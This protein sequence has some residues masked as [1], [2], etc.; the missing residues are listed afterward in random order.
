M[1][2]ILQVDDLVKRFGGVLAT[3]N[4]AL[5][6]EPGEVHALIGPN[7]AGKTTL[8]S[9]LFGELTPDAGTIRFG[10]QAIG[11]LS[12]ADRVQRGLS[13]TFQI[14][15][16]LREFTVLENVAMAV[17]VRRGHSFH[18]WRN[19]RRDRSLS[20]AAYGILRGAGLGD[21]ADVVVSELSHGEQ[22]QLEL[23]VALA[24]EPRLLLLDEPMAGLGPVESEA[25][26]A[27]LSKLKGQVA[28]L[29]V[30]HDMDAV[31]QLADRVSVLVYGRIIATGTAEE[32]RK[33]EEV[34][35]AYLGEGDD[36]C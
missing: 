27:Y 28:M 12:T 17:Q 24:S 35:A 34:R 25:M 32:I 18:F 13:R 2:P 22:K 19:A 16:L 6:V 30:E 14:T 33:N 21:R 1:T 15:H 36:A 9:Q 3:Q 8:I 23:A 7:G 29:L 20:E 5:T 10:G 26:I 4:V 31:F 11:S